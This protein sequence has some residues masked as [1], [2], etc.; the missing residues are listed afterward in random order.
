LSKKICYHRCCVNSA[1]C[2]LRR[3]YMATYEHIGITRKDFRPA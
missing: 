2:G 3:I 1:N